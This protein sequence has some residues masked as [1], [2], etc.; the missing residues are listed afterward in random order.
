MEENIRCLVIA[1]LA[2]RQC[3]AWCNAP[4]ASSAVGHHLPSTA[5][6]LHI[7]W[8]EHPSFCVQRILYNRKDVPT[9]D[10]ANKG[11]TRPSGVA[12]RDKMTR[13]MSVTFLGTS[14]GGGPVVN[15]NCSS[16]ALDI[17][18]SGSLWRTSVKYLF[19]KRFLS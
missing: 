14:S 5:F 15:R 17:A 2:K 4:G 16:I 1:C 7:L 10:S 19:R 18:G 13:K 6:I 8:L 12:A 3:G 9:G 11:G